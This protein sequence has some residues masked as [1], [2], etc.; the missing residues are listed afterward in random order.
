MTDSRLDLVD[1]SASLAKKEYRKRVASAQRRLLQLRL[2]FAGLI[3]DQGLGPP[4]CLVFE[5][6]DSAGKG[7]AIKRLVAGLD[8]RHVR[9][10]QYAAPSEYEL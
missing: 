1:L 6:W 9:V 4:V 10:V 5:G 3:G 7:G 2:V 8:P